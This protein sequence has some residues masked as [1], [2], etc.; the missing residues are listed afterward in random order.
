[1]NLIISASCPCGCSRPLPL[2]LELQFLGAFL[3]LMLNAENGILGQANAFSSDLND[4]WLAG[5]KRI[6]QAAQFEN[7]LFARN[8]FFKIPI[9]PAF[10]F[11]RHGN[12]LAQSDMRRNGE[13]TFSRLC[14]ATAM[15]LSLLSG[16]KPYFPTNATCGK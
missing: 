5:F 16:F 14:C 15:L 12:G 7:E 10:R 3:P 1:M 6:G 11:R 9:L 8:G 2:H 13:M 4:E